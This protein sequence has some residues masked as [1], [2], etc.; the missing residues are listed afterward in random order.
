[1]ARV[2]GRATRSAAGLMS[3]MLLTCFSAT[4]SGV[5]LIASAVDDTTSFIGVITARSI[6]ASLDVASTG[7]ARAGALLTTAL[8]A[9]VTLLTDGATALRVALRVVDVV[10]RT[11]AATLLIEGV[12]ARLTAARLDAARVRETCIGALLTTALTV[13][14]TRLNASPQNP[15]R[16]GS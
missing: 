14:V 10:L 8:T 11:D 9:L 1:M 12:T 3:Q 6:A 4:L 16:V 13:R 7:D 15:S 5:V 2:A